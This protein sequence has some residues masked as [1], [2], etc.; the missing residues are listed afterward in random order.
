MQ[1]AKNAEPDTELQLLLVKSVKTRVAIV[2][3]KNIRFVTDV[4]LSIKCNTESA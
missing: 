3:I 1:D 4:S 2:V